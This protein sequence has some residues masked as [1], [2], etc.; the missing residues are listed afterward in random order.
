MN[1]FMLKL[2]KF[3]QTKISVHTPP[4]CRYR[5]T[6]SEYGK[7]CYQRFGFFKATYLTTTRILRCNRLFKMRIDYPPKI[8]I[9][10]KNKR[11]KNEI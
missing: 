5:P 11:L 9:K 8:K 2:I 1:K 6:C 4:K 10:V 7:I 3:Y